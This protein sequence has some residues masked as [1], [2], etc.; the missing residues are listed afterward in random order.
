MDQLETI[1][2]YAEGKLSHE[3]FEAELNIDPSLWD[4]VQSLVPEDIARPDHP[5][6][7]VYG[8]MRLLETNG[9]RVKPALLV[10]GY[11]PGFAYDL[12]SKLVQYRFTEV[13]CREPLDG[14]VCDLLAQLHVDDLAGTETESL[15]QTL[16][17]EGKNSSRKAQKQSILEAFHIENSRLR[18]RW[19]QEPEWPMGEK[20]PMKFQGQKRTGE[21]V[22]YL[23]RDVDTGEERVV[24]Q[25]Y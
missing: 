11:R 14:P 21:R 24:E 5:F 23:F 18:P 19:A 9:Y 15:L 7:S 12:I 22:R 17:L 4:A 6:R 13:R 25:L 3:E 2:R 20:S 8:N 10:F 16:L 1:V